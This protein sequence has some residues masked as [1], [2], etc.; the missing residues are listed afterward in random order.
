MVLKCRISP[1][2]KGS[3]LEREGRGTDVLMNKEDAELSPLV[4]SGSADY[5]LKS[6]IHPDL[7]PDLLMAVCT[8]FTKVLNFKTTTMVMS[9]IKLT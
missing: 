3:L 6:Q 2:R 8:G 5:V 9:L 7:H 4:V 1:L